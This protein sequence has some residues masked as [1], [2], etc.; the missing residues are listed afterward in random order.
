MVTRPFVGDLRD[1][2]TQVVAATEV[3]AELIWQVVLTTAELLMQD[4]AMVLFVPLLSG[5]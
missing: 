5:T 1:G 2:A 3:G 4:S